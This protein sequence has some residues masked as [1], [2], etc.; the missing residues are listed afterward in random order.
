VVHRAFDPGVSLIVEPHSEDQSLSYGL[1]AQVVHAT[2]LDAY[3]WLGCVFARLLDG[4]EV[5]TLL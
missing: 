1:L 2:P 5:Q 4:E 3:R